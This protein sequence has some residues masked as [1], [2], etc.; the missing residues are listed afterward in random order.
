MTTE[1]NTAT[2]PVLNRCQR[3]TD[4]DFEL[5]ADH[6]ALWCQQWSLT[7]SV[8]IMRKA[9]DLYNDTAVCILIGMWYDL[10]LVT[11]KNEHERLMRGANGSEWSWEREG[12]ED[13]FEP[14]NSVDEDELRGYNDALHVLLVG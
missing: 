4:E 11:V 10:K 5:F 9:R 12:A 8:P 6:L 1:S 7:T 14:C 13:E 3:D 2:V